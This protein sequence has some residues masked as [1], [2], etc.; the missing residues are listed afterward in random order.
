MKWHWQKAGTVEH[1][2]RVMK[3][4]LG[5]GVLPSGK[6]GANAAWFRLNVLTHNLLAV[7]KRRALPE[8]YLLA[9]PKRLRFELFTIP[10]RI[11]EHEGRLLR[12]P[13]RPRQFADERHL[14]EEP[15]SAG[16]Y[17][18]RFGVTRRTAQKDLE[19]L[20]TEEIVKK[21]GQGKNTRYRFV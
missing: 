17:A 8:R 21:E 11:K 13:L 10:A 14:I 19:H 6:F 2:H 3:D 18:T 7:L 15:F 20:L 16:V 9:R 4:E 5:A 12:L 1:I